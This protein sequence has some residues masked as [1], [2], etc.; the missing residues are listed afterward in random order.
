LEVT[1]GER[2]QSDAQK[3]G[4][5][6]ST[7][8]KLRKQAKDGALATFAGAKSGKARPVVHCGVDEAASREH[9]FGRDGEGAGVRTGVDP[10]EKLAGVEPG[11]N[12]L[13]PKCRRHQRERGVESDRRVT[14]RSSP[15][16]RR[17]RDLGPKGPSVA[18]PVP[19]CGLCGRSGSWRQAGASDPPLGGESRP[20]LDRGVES[21]RPVPQETGPRRCWC[22]RTRPLYWA[23]DRD[24][25]HVYDGVGRRRGGAAAWG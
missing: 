24:D 10:G 21:Q 11:P 8:I 13:R 20:R 7:V 19:E 17:P 23:A 14:T 16:D 5:D 18:V 4:V 12:R 9:S 22:Q 2:V 25:R 1:S 3:S 6:V 15:G